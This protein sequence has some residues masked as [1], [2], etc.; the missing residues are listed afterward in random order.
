[1]KYLSLC[2]LWGLLLMLIMNGASLTDLDYHLGKS[3]Y[4]DVALSE[5]ESF[6]GDTSA[7]LSVSDK[8]TYIRISVYMDQPI[9]LED[10]DLLSMW[11]DPESGDGQIQL[12]LFMDGDGDGSYNSK[13][14]NDTRIRSLKESW[15]RRGM[16]SNQWNELDG[17]DLTYEKYGDKGFSVGSLESCRERLSGQKVVKLYITLYKDKN[18]P[19]T[20]AFIDYI[21]IADQLISFEPLENEAIKDGPTSVSPGSTITYTITY[22]NNLL[23]PV[24]LVVREDYDPATSFVRADPEPDPG[25]TN[26]WTIRSLP[27]GKHGQIVVKIA[28]AKL[29]C[30]AEIRGKVS[31]SGFTAVREDLSTDVQSYDVTNTVTLTCSEFNMTASAT[32]AVR[33]VKGSILNYEAHG[34]GL[35]NSQELIGYSPTK[36]VAY[37]EIASNSAPVWLNISL[38][39]IVF[40]GSWSARQRWENKPRDLSWS[41]SYYQARLLNL[42]FRTQLTKS[43]TYQETSSHFIGL[44]D[45]D[46]LLNG[47]TIIQMFAGNYTLKSKATAAWSSRRPST[48]KSWLDFCSEDEASETEPDQE[49]PDN[50]SSDGD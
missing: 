43:L 29:S 31:G 17:F 37:R 18:V 22:G 38:E 16:I 35:Y 13:D 15:S 2:F 41:E 46:S 28:T 36:I 47:A 6:H 48:S 23:E 44:A 10:L 24:D 39:P 8:G 33:A 27:P 20:S 19:K 30:K 4:G 40:Q 34:S 49:T 45:R 1:M 9:S 42:S 50:E 3:K 11:I 7:E 12:D 32:T 25:T 14:S 5:E 26:V 21:K